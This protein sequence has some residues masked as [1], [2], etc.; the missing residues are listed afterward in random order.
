[1][2]GRPR[3]EEL[4]DPPGLG[5]MMQLA[6][7][8]TVFRPHLVL[9]EHGR[10]RETPKAASGLPEK[11]AA[12]Q[13]PR[14]LPLMEGRFVGHGSVGEGEF[15]QI[16]QHPAHGGQ[17][18]GF[19]KINQR[20]QGRGIRGAAERE[21]MGAADLAGE[22]RPLLLHALREV[23]RLGQDESVIQ[24]REGLQ[25]REAFIALVHPHGGIGTIQR[26][27]PRLGLRAHN[28]AVDGTTPRFRVSGVGQTLLIVR[29]VFG[30]LDH[31]I[32]PAG[33][34]HRQ[35]EFSA[36]R[37]HRVAYCLRFEFPAVLAP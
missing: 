31:E 36:H 7:R 34:T 8:R 37:E 5:W 25:R 33:P 30:P 24:Q 23:L 29:R 9:T 17:P 2:A 10:E 28:A 15:V 26:G 6:G 27:H 4:H 13:L 32:L 18:I 20:G 1:M 11:L 14:S 12:R 19:G 21:F 35:V 16:E 22:I 3:H